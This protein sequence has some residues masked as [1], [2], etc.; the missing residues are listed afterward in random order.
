MNATRSLLSI[1]PVVLAL[2]SIPGNAS[3]QTENDVIAA[4]NAF[5]ATPQSCEGRPTPPAGRLAPNAALAS[6]VVAPDGKL[7]DEL[8]VNGYRAAEAYVIV[9]SGPPSPAPLMK[10]LEQRYCQPLTSGQFTEAGVRHAG[11]HWQIILAK[12]L[13]P[14]DLRDWRAEGEE[15]LRLTNQARASPR[16]CGGRKFGPAQPLTWDDRLAAASLAHSRDM[17][18]RNYLA[19][20]GKDGSNPGVR[21][22]RHGYP[23]LE[24]GENVAGGQGS[25]MRVVTGWLGSPD[26]CENLMNDRFV[27]MGAAYAVNPRSD[28]GIAW[29]QMFGRT[30]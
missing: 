13:R 18:N 30:P 9:V 10:Y 11:A 1:L 21:A 14:R 6:R 27:N 23:W 20:K 19:H 8:K 16:S 15:I 5:R 4:I 12:P 2:A 29:T 22:S 7:L 3:A 28:T 25:A 26:H 24:V 17:A